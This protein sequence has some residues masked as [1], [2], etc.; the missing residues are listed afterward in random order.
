MVRRLMAKPIRINRLISVWPSEIVSLEKVFLGDPDGWL[1][2]RVR[3]GNLYQTELVHKVD[4]ECPID[5]A[6]LCARLETIT[7]I[8]A[9]NIGLHWAPGSLSDH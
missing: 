3:G 1:N 7:G 5:P 9:I 8:T 6:E 4:P 2:V